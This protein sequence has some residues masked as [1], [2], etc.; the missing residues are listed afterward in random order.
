M[1]INAKSDWEIVSG[2]FGDDIIFIKDL[3]KGRMSV[4]NDAEAI[5]VYLQNSYGGGSKAR[6]MGV[7]VVYQDSENEW[8]EMTQS[9]Q[10]YYDCM[11]FEKWHGLV[12]DTLK[13][14]TV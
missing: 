4:T 9:W 14:K 13:R 6:A 11:K 5:F 7:R 8:W 12:W 1:Y 10:T 3:N 2:K